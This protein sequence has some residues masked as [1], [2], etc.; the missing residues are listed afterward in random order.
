MIGLRTVMYPACQ[1]LVARQ[2]TNVQ[3]SFIV[4]KNRDISLLSLVLG[5]IRKRAAKSCAFVAS[6]ARR[7]RKSAE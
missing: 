1:Y 4:A 3:T 6:A 2:T 7:Q 5:L